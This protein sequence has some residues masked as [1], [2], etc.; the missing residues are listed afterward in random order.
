[1]KIKL[2]LE[3]SGHEPGKGIPP[4]STGKKGPNAALGSSHTKGMTTPKDH[5]P[6]NVSALKG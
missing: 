1:M 4:I 6:H 3:K 5:K 2:P